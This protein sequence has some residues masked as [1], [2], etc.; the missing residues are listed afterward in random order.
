MQGK[1]V[2]R[3]SILLPIFLTKGLIYQPQCKL[4]HLV[5]PREHLEEYLDSSRYYIKFFPLPCF[6]RFGLL[7]T[8]AVIHILLLYDAI[9]EICHLESWS[10]A[11]TSMWPSYQVIYCDQSILKL[12]S[13][14]RCLAGQSYLRY[15]SF[16]Y[17]KLALKIISVKG[18][19]GNLFLIPYDSNYER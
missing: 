14:W 12:I 18:E 13:L 11:G 8:S 3:I 15:I 17:R 6:V 9:A 2:A 10:P 7:K 4:C 5:L 16:K 19:S 1:S